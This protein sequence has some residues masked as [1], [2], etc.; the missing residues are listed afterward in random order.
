MTNTLH[1]CYAPETL[2]FFTGPVCCIKM[3]PI[4]PYYY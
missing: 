4:P 3:Y 1:Q 2:M